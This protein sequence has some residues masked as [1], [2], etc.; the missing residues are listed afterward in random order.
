MLC[1][2]QARMSSTRF[3][4][5]TL[6]LL[7]GITIL[8]RVVARLQNAA[9]ITDLVVAT[10]EED[11][12]YPIETLCR[13]KGYACAR[14]SLNNVADR[15]I[16]IAATYKANEFIRISGDSPFIDPVLVDTAVSLYKNEGNLDLVTNVFPRTFPK[17]QSVEIIKTVIMLEGYKKFDTPDDYEHVTGF[18]YRHAD[19]YN[20]L[21]FE[22]G[23]NY[24]HVSMC[25]DT[26]DDMKRMENLLRGQRESLS[27]WSTITRNLLTLNTNFE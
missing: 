19:Q 1:I 12:D 11:S 26:Q 18:F 13:E 3:K 21:N 23:G 9:K 16:K 8:E 25:I 27:D 10:S 20:I 24:A 2:V 22:S 14:G 6:Q 5:K 7:D 15:F 17:G 4:G